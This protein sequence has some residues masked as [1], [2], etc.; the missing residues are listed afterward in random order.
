MIELLVNLPNPI[1]KLQHAPLPP[2][3]YELESV[4]QLFLLPLSFT[5]ET[6]S[7]SIKKLGGTSPEI[8]ENGT[9]AIYETHNLSRPP[10][11]VKS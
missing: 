2:K 3:C 8:L 1:P 5:F 9:I 7:E 4:P 10:I 6:Q 11:E